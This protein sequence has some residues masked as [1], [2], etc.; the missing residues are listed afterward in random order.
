MHVQDGCLRVDKEEPRHL[1]SFLDRLTQRL[2]LAKVARDEAKISPEELVYETVFERMHIVRL[3]D[4]L[5]GCNFGRVLADNPHDRVH[6]GKEVPANV[7]S[8]CMSRFP[9]KITCNV[10]LNFVDVL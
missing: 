2:Q 6:E 5:L 3:L 9:L 1:I 4:G 10:P 8:H 7:L